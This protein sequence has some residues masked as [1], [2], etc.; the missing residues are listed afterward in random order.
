L[1]DYKNARDTKLREEREQSREKEEEDWM[2]KLA[3]T[4]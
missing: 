1:W 2:M 3:G 4:N